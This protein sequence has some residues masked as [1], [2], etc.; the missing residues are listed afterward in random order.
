MLVLTLHGKNAAQLPA[1]LGLVEGAAPSIKFPWGSARAFLLK[2]ESNCCAV[3]LDLDLADLVT[4]RAIANRPRIAQYV[5]A[6]KYLASVLLT[7][8]L[9]GLFKI[10]QTND[11]PHLEGDFEVQI[12][13]IALRDQGELAQKMVEGFGYAIAIKG[14]A[15]F[16]SLSYRGTKSLAELLVETAILIPA[17]DRDSALWWEKANA[18]Q[19]ANFAQSKLENHPFATEIV[20]E[21]QKEVQ[22]LPSANTR[23]LQAFFE[24]TKALPSKLDKNEIDLQIEAAQS[25]IIVQ[26]FGESQQQTFL[27]IGLPAIEMT[28]E[29]L[30]TESLR[31]FGITELSIKDLQDFAAQLNSLQLP[32]N[33]GNILRLFSSAA[34]FQNSSYAEYA[35]IAVPMLNR[36]FRKFQLPAIT[37]SLFKH[38]APEL[39]WISGDNAAFNAETAKSNKKKDGEL[40]HWNAKQAK[41]WADSTATA[42][43]YVLAFH[44]F[45]P[46]DEEK[47]PA[48]W[49]ATFHKGI[50]R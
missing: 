38:A 6:G 13:A 18:Q 40:I 4:T 27:S 25:K 42:H 35:A 49:M 41:T 50:H 16:V 21:I 15:P 11:I 1:A 37:S 44:E 29:I 46:K 47:N 3:A 19:F 12:A 2:N 34:I 14:D 10:F 17:M 36:S 28:L 26:E 48:A 9:D 31:L 45:G 32:A 24:K 22:E 30:K 7:Q 33:A 5:H 39:L 43:G 8:A 20:Q 23:N